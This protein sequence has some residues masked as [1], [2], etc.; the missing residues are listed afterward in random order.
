MYR[1]VLYRNDYY[2][3]CGENCDT[4]YDSLEYSGSTSHES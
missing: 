3:Y 4:V 2:V 1:N